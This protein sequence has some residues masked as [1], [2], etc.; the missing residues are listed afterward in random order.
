LKAVAAQAHGGGGAF[1]E[2]LFAQ[3]VIARRLFS[4]ERADAFASGPLDDLMCDRGLPDIS[5]GQ[6]V[7]P[8]FAVRF[9]QLPYHISVATDW[10]LHN[11]PAFKG[12]EVQPRISGKS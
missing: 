3:P 6:G 10:T 1:L 11:S 8:S 2:R 9:Q 12:V 4:A 7:E 5:V